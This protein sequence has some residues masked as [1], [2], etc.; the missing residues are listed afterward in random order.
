M[1]P[2]HNR[3]LLYVSHGE[4]LSFVERIDRSHA[5]LATKVELMPERVVARVKE[6]RRLDRRRFWRNLFALLV[7]IST[8]VGAITGV[9]LLVKAFV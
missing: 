7:G 6:D 5:E 3:P 8:I 1:P 4:F 2:E 9:I